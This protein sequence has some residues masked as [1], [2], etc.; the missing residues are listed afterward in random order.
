MTSAGGREQIRSLYRSLLRESHA[1][2][3]DYLRCALAATC[4]LVPPDLIRVFY[5]I[6]SRQSIQ[7]I[8]ETDTNNLPLLRSKVGRVKAVC[9]VTFGDRA[10]LMTIVEIAQTSSC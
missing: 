9:R 4:A 5:H 10:K 2:P 6:K 3:V 1:L 8:R 7:A